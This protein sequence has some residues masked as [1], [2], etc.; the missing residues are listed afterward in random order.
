MPRKQNLPGFEGKSI[1]EVEDAAE[2]YVEARDSRMAKQKIE[3]DC[4][5][6]LML[7][8]GKH[9]LS[10][11]EYDGKTVAVVEDKKVRVRQSKEDGGDE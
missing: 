9:K 5:D 3:K 10:A 4:H 11:Y 8:M 7:L 6:R 1:K 2:D